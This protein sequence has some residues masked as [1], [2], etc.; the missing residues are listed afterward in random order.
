MREDNRYN[1]VL[2]S[3]IF[4]YFTVLMMLCSA[5]QSIREKYPEVTGGGLLV[6]HGTISTGSTVMN[7]GPRH[8]N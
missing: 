5:Y 7:D 2:Y 8:P 3:W 4:V 6:V 1:A